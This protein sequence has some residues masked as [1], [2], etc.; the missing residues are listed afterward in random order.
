MSYLEQSPAFSFD[1]IVSIFESILRGRLQGL[2]LRPLLLITYITFVDNCI[3]FAADTTVYIVDNHNIVLFKLYE[4]LVPNK[5][6]NDI[7]IR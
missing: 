6:A 3:L 7:E 1:N 5:N 2:I 4:W